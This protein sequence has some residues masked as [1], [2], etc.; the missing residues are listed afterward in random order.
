MAIPID[1][2][3]A[4]MGGEWNVGG[5]GGMGQAGTTQVST[6]N[7]GGSDFGGM[8]A[9]QISSLEQTQTQASEAS[10]SL[11]T[12]QATDPTSVVMAVERARLSMEFASTMR[13]KAVESYQEIF[14]T[15]V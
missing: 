7:E 5:V 10:R 6:P 9:D 8:L 12:G 13:N 11:A 14:R 3:M 15:Q 4:T 1:P 2:S